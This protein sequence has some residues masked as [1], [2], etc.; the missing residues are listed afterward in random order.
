M[1]ASPIPGYQARARSANVSRSYR[2]GARRI[3]KRFSTGPM[4]L[5]LFDLWGFAFLVTDAAAQGDCVALRGDEAVL[6]GEFLR[7]NGWK[8]VSLPSV[9][10]LDKALTDLDYQDEMPF[11]YA[12]DLNGDRAPEYLV[13]TPNGRLCGTGGCPYILLAGTPMKRIGEFFGHLAIL[14]ARVNGYRII[15]TFSRY[16]GTTTSLDTYVFDG[17]AYRLSS[18]VILESC[19]FEQWGRRIRR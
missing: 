19:G 5:A 4:I 9:G 6:P 11:V 18:H 8:T 7:D 12:V 1:N 14:D 10:D 15:Q 17:G 13:A 2:W 16:Q 3:A